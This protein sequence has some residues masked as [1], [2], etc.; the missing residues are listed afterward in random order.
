M[1][2]R[3]VLL[4]AEDDAGF[5]ELFKC[6]LEKGG[7]KHNIAHVHDGEQAIAYLNGEG[8]YADRMK[9][10][11]PTVALLDLKMP[12]V[13]GFE[14]LDWIRNKS[15]FPFLPVVVLTVSDEIRDINKAYAMGAN[16]FLIKPPSTED[17]KNM[18]EMLDRY[19]F[20][21]EVKAEW[22]RQQAKRPVL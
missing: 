2:R 21:H 1:F 15:P 4:Y 9:F 14:V 3:D 19:W 12:R 16:S 5:A 13:N 7:F 20:Q 10:P 6:A 22:Q 8:G 11:L 18:L 17:L